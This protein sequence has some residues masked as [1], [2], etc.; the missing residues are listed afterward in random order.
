VLSSFDDLRY[1][2]ALDRLGTARSAGRELGVAASTVYRR[3]AALEAA[4][5]FVC[6]QRGDGL[7]AAGRELAALGRS[8]GAALARIERH[9]RADRDEIRGKVTLTTVDGFAPLLVAPLAALA[10]ASPQLQIAVH[11][12]DSG[13]SLRKR[14]AE[15]GLSVLDAPPETLV[16][17]RLFPVRFGVFGVKTVV[18]D[19]ENARWVTLGAPLHTSWLGRWESEHVDADRI[20]VASPSRR[21][22][23]DLV[24]AGVG[25]GLL[26][27]P[28]AEAHPELVELSSY[29]AKAAS[30]T[31]HAWLLTHA[32]AR[33]DPRVGAL[34][35]TLIRHLARKGG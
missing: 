20:A 21:L 7:T 32:D 6:L 2:E 27:A 9:A 16:G 13:L 23:V 35:E 28:L 17:R 12:S 19:A 26:P 24:V 34:L 14:Q 31:R 25:L 33:K 29:R 18:A 10:V 1:L 4:V 3:V 22:L 5:G 11:I 8:T 30:L 15:V